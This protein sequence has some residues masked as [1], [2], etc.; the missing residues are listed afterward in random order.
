MFDSS[1][2]AS[3][4]TCM[5]AVHDSEHVEALA[6]KMW[7]AYVRSQP[8]EDRRMH[9]SWDRLTDHETQRGFRSVARMV[10]RDLA[11]KTTARA[12][13][14]ACRVSNRRKA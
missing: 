10:L 9:A 2:N 7:S 1:S 12:A 14:A 5:V 8:A 11:P 13:K 4:T 6:R 3:Y